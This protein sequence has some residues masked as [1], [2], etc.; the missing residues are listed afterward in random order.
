M[1]FKDEVPLKNGDFNH[2]K[3]GLIHDKL[4]LNHQKEDIWLQYSYDMIVIWW[5]Y[6]YNS[7]VK[8]IV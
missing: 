4:W 8:T 3:D 2:E 1:K 5:N 7:V 6:C